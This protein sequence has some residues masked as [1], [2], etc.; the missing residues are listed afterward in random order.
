M[1]TVNETPISLL[2]DYC[3]ARKHFYQLLQVLFYQPLTEPTLIQLKEEG[4]L[5]DLQE[6]GQGGQFLYQF[7]MQASE[8]ELIEAKTDFNQLFVGP[9]TILAPPWESV[10]RSREHLLFDKTTHQ[11]REQYHNFGLQFIQ[12]N[13]EPDDHLSIELEFLMHLNDLCLNEE[14]HTRLVELLLKQI[15]FLD[16]HLLQWIPLFTEKIIKSAK[17]DLYK[18][19]GMLLNDFL[20]FDIDSLKEFEEAMTN[21]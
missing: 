11:V 15:Y 5:P 20:V 17:T 18:G 8:T 3:K 14:H 4:N 2:L 6:M 7:F 21:V 19:A 1:Q 10:Y 16:E 13:N 9:G 12:E